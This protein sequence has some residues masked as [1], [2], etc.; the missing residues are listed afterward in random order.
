MVSGVTSSA[1]SPSHT[2]MMTRRRAELVGCDDAL[3][4]PRPSTANAKVTRKMNL[5]ISLR[6]PVQMQLPVPHRALILW[7]IQKERDV[8][9]LSFHDSDFRVRPVSV[10]PR[11]DG[12]VIK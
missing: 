7:R 12:A 5:F 9:R 4:L 8:D 3:P 11:P 2:K 1:R 6:T 10:V